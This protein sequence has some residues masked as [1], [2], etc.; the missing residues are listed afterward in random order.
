VTG[1]GG[2]Y[3]GSGGGGHHHMNEQQLKFKTKD[4]EV[5][6]YDSLAAERT[7]LGRICHHPFC[8]PNYFKFTSQRV[9]FTKWDWVPLKLCGLEKL[10]C[11]KCNIP[12]GRTLEF[13]DADLLQDVEAYQRVSQICLNE[14]DLYLL[15]LAGGDLDNS[16]S[17]FKINAVPEVYKLF[18]DLSYDLSRLQL[19]GFAANAMGHRMMQS[20]NAAAFDHDPIVDTQ[21][22]GKL[23]GVTLYTRI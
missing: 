21:P 1:G 12:C 7:F 23:R 17:R 2:D 16:N 9:L 14:G 5:V 15:R 3:S 19:K 6:F 8:C 22:G 4:G 20:S 10:C 11:Y 18:D 13:F